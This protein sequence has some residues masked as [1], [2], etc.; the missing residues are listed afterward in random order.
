MRKLALSALLAAIV[1]THV[2]QAQATSGSAPPASTPAPAE[3]TPS[4][5]TSSTPAP[6]PSAT[7]TPSAPAPA[8]QPPV[9]TPAPPATPTRQMS[10]SALEDK[11]LIGANSGEVGD[12]ES[13]VESNADKKRHIVISRGGFLG[14]FETEVAI[15]LENVAVRNDQVVLQNLTEEQLKALPKYENSNN[16]YRVL[17][18]S[19]SISLA[20]AK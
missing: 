20:E 13:V 3:A 8:T 10:V 5:G 18:D 15:P 11:D 16:A 1:I 14:F 12:I 9:A 19:E 2:G 6:S 17:D 4:P 7:T